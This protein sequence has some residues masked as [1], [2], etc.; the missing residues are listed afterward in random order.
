MESIEENRPN[1]TYQMDFEGSDK[2]EQ[3]TLNIDQSV[4]VKVKGQNID[5]QQIGYHL[6]NQNQGKSQ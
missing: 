2:N 4:N 5:K 1:S 6:A 3:M